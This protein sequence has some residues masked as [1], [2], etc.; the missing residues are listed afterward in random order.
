MRVDIINKLP[1]RGTALALNKWCVGFEILKCPSGM[2]NIFKPTLVIWCFKFLTES[3]MHLVD[4]RPALMKG[5]RKYFV[6]PWGISIEI[7]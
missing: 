4:G 5:F 3:T 7:H 1:D 6:F 2:C